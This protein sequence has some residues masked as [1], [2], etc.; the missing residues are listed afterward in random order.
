MVSTVTLPMVF[1][2]GL[3]MSDA[4]NALPVLAYT[5]LIFIPVPFPN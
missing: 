1:S 3:E 5:S 2:M 4:F